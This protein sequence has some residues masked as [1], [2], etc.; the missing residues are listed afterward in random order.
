MESGP[1]YLRSGAK[2]AW[3]LV[4]YVHPEPVHSVEFVLAVAKALKLRKPPH[5]ADRAWLKALKRLVSSKEGRAKLARL[6]TK[7]LRRDRNLSSMCLYS[8]PLDAP[9]RIYAPT[10]SEFFDVRGSR[11]AYLL[12]P[13]AHDGVAWLGTGDAHLER[14]ERRRALQSFFA[15]LLPLVGTVVLPHHGSRHNITTRFIQD[16]PG[17]TWIAPYGRK[18][19]YR[20]PDKHVMRIARAYGATVRVNE[21]SSTEFTEAMGLEWPIGAVAS[22]RTR[23]SS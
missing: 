22:S 15:K 18:N 19:R 23:A 5:A 10:E 1:I 16:L 11:F 8:G 9:I 13:M 14:T 3:V 4:P 20:H 21:E 12:R 7:H 17:R 2:A 6:S